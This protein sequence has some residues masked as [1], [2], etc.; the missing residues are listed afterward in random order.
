MMKATTKNESRMNWAANGD[1]LH[2]LLADVHERIAHQP[3]PQAVARI[4]RRLQAEI[5]APTRAAA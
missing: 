3:S 1:W 5:K 4:R 2:R